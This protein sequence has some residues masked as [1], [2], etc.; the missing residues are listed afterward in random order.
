MSITNLQKY[1]PTQLCNSKEQPRVSV[2]ADRIYGNS[3]A[4]NIV[5]VNKGYIPSAVVTPR[6]MQKAFVAVCSTI[7]LDGLLYRYWSTYTGVGKS[8]FTV[9]NTRNK[10][11]ILLLYV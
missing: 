4:M 2:T 5:T 11:L 10:E 1:R 8:R 9:V 6:G 3:H 7:S